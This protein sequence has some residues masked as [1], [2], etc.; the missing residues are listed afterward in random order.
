[1]CCEVVGQIAYNADR[2][3]QLSIRLHGD[4]NVVIVNETFLLGVVYF[5]VMRRLMGRLNRGIRMS[6]KVVV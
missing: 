4:E 2:V 1:M 6:M 5:T 3:C